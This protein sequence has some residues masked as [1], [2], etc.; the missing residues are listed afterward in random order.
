[1]FFQLQPGGLQSHGQNICL[2]IRIHAHRRSIDQKFFVFLQLSLCASHLFLLA[3]DSVPILPRLVSGGF[4]GG[5]VGICK[6]HMFHIF[7]HMG[8]MRGAVMRLMA[9]HRCMLALRDFSIF[10]CLVDHSLFRHLLIESEKNPA[11]RKNV[12]V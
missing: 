1:M 11:F 4:L 3:K 9:H 6:G 12:D 5:F 7:Q 10:E 2:C 8:D